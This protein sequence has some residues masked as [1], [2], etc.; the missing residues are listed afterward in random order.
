VKI[1]LNF[2][3]NKGLCTFASM[4]WLRKLFFPLVPIYY[5]GALIN[6]KL[7]DWNIKK[8]KTYNFPL[9]TVGNLS[10]GGTGKSPMVAYLVDL[11]HA[12]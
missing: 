4:N 12:I 5:L 3:E 7:Y 10:V 1:Q 6:K 2:I 9:I 8:S 11:L